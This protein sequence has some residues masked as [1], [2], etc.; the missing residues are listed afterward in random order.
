VAATK[1]RRRPISDED[2]P[3][4]LALSAGADSVE[5]KLT[6]PEAAH[7]SAIRALELDPLDAQIRLVC[8]FD[9]PDLALDKH[10]VIVRARRVQGRED[11]SVVKLRPVVPGDLPDELRTAPGMVVELDAMPE[12]YVCSA[13]LKARLGAS[14]V[15]KRVSGRRATRK[16]FSKPQRAFYTQH[17]P[18]G[19]ELD[20]LTLLGPIFVLKLNTTPPAFRRKLTTEMW[21]YPDGSRILELSTK[22]T[23]ADM[24]QVAFEARG[25]LMGLG[26][27]LSGQQQTKTKTALQQFA[28]N[29]NGG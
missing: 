18:D 27:D 25:F 11:D 15:K 2:L 9:T 26:V 7:G 22:C 10:G 17:A 23:P 6:V 8:F 24:F 29:L 19:V 5:L 4:V 1:T 13:S 16:L 20:D 28:R 12:G 21:L 14:D 3:Q